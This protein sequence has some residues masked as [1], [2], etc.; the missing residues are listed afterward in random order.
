MEP[1]LL[2]VIAI[3]VISIVGIIGWMVAITAS[4]VMVGT[5]TPE[6][7]AV[8]PTHV[9]ICHLGSVVT[10]VVWPIGTLLS[11]A[12]VVSGLVV[13]MTSSAEAK[14]AGWAAILAGGS[15]LA[16]LVAISL[17]AFG[18]MAAFMP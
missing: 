8:V 7:R 16:L 13:L 11:L 3:V 12:A 6:A 2:P 14:R 9:W 1:N 10:S 5:M 15:Y 4:A 17:S 18:Y